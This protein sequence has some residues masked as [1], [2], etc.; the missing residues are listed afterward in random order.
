MYAIC[1]LLFLFL[2]CCYFFMFIF[3]LSPLLCF[4]FSYIL[5]SFQI[6]SKIKEGHKLGSLTVLFCLQLC[7]VDL[8]LSRKPFF[9]QA[10]N[11]SFHPTHN[12]FLCFSCSY[13]SLFIMDCI[14]EVP[15]PPSSQGLSKKHSHS[16]LKTLILFPSPYFLS[17]YVHSFIT[18]S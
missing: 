7:I 12:C 2:F 4:V 1:Y 6:F 11:F 10:S 18:L 16:C 15:M 9:I 17:L 13:F 8:L 3:F 5:L 14:N